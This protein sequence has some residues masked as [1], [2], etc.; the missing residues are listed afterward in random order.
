[1]AVL[2]V[3]IGFGFTKASNGN[4]QIMLKSIFGDAVDIQFHSN[5]GKMSQIDKL[6][7]TLGDHSYFVGDYAEQQSNVRQFTLDQDKLINDFIRILTLSAAGRFSEADK[8]LGIVSGLPAGFF[9]EN[10]KQ[11]AE[12]LTGKHHIVFHHPDRT[13]SKKT[14]YIKK[15]RMMPQPLGSFFNLLM[16][17][18]GKII[19]KDL[20]RQKVGIIDIGFRTTDISIFDRLEYIDRG[21][22]TMDTGIAK[23]F[24]II[25]GKLQEKSGIRIELYRLYDAVET[26]VIKMRGQEYNISKIKDQVF[27]QSAE[28]I[29]NDVERLWSN[30]WD[31]DAIILTGGGGM[32]LSK[33]LNPLITGNIILPELNTDARLNN[34]TGYIKYGKHIWGDSGLCIPT[35]EEQPEKAAVNYG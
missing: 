8:P 20:A 12:L 35:A 27:S 10:S 1:M 26:G 29:A 19:N 9:K 17:D 30:D 32:A 21:S 23:S 6:H 34:V 16:D 13:E 4:E 28:T 31:I 33:Y 15:I 22:A 7:V 25:A 2:G 3:D 24:N 14:I 5:V 11:V 18:S